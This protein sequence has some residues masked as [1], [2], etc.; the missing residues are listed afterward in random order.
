ML[1]VTPAK[2]RNVDEPRIPRLLAVGSVK[3]N[4]PYLNQNL[5]EKS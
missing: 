2:A 4:S 1:V 5:A 3:K